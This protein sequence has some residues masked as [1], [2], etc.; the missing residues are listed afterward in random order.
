MATRKQKTTP[1]TNGK[2]IQPGQHGT[3]LDFADIKGTGIDHVPEATELVGSEVVVTAGPDDEGDVQV[4]LRSGRGLW[5]PAAAIEPV[6]DPRSRSKLTVEFD[7]SDFKTIEEAMKRL[8]EHATWYHGNLLPY[9]LALF[10]QSL[11]HQGINEFTLGDRVSLPVAAFR[12]AQIIWT[13][14]ARDQKRAGPQHH[15]LEG[16]GIG[17]LIG[18]LMAGRGGPANQEPDH[19]Q[20]KPDAEA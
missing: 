2:T 7:V 8:I 20:P 14:M 19:Q 9:R 4:M 6:D 17:D 5:W 16:A 18:A 3:L 12:M 1:S 11:T 10:G 15:A 13:S